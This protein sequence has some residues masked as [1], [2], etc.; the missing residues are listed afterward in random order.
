MNRMQSAHSHKSPSA[1]VGVFFDKLGKGDLP[2]IMET[3][4]AEAKWTLHGPKEIPFAGEHV[5]KEGIQAFIETFG[6]N[7]KVLRFEP[8]E[9]MADKSK[10]VVNGHEEV[11]AIPTGKTWKANWTMCFTVHRGKI[12]L[13]DEALNTA[14][15]LAAFTP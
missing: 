11:V 4:A 3:F 12:I 15:V 13:V 9:F 7:S 1:V 8:K 14:P 10:V 2:G 6:K 5:G